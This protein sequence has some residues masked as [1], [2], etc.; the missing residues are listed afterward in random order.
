MPNFEKLAEAEKDGVPVVRVEDRTLRVPCEGSNDDLYPWDC[1]NGK[2]WGTD[3]DCTIC[4]GRGWICADE[5][6]AFKLVLE[7]ALQTHSIIL[8]ANPQY[9]EGEV[10]C[11]L[12]SMEDVIQG[13]GT[14]QAALIAAAEKLIEEIELSD[15]D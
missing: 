11:T 15:A 3:K 5:D 8:D 13:V 6:K 7:W 9:G 2:I 4:Q 14:L 1:D 12:G 10:V